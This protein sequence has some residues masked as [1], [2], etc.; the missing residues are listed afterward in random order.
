MKKI[1]LEDVRDIALEQY[2]K[3]FSFFDMEDFETD[4]KDLA[5]AKKMVSRFL[6]TETINQNFVLNKV[7]IATNVFGAEVA[8]AIFF[9]ICTPVQFSVI[10]ACMIYQRTYTFKLNEDIEPHRIMVDI[11][12][13][14]NRRG[15]E[16]LPR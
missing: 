4:F 14:M 1:D 13:D 7:I 5:V 6:T 15:A 9:A 12:K 8:E 10:K 3:R 2:R 16:P 11:L